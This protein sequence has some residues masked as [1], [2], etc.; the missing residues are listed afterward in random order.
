MRADGV[1]GPQLEDPL[2]ARLASGKETSWLRP[3]LDPAAQSLGACSLPEGLVE[4]ARRRFRRFAP[5][6]A[7][8]FPQTRAADGIIESPLERAGA[9]QSRMGELLGAELPG[10]LWVK[11]DDT[12]PV[13]G[14]I[15][16]RGGFH[17]VLQVVEGIVESEQLGA[18]GSDGHRLEGA[19][20]VGALRDPATARTLH[21][22]GIA[23]GSTGNLGLSIGLLAAEFGLRATVHM[24]TDA[25]PWKKDMLRSRGVEVVEHA[26]DFSAAVA[27]G[28]TAAGADPLTHFVDDES[29]LS[30][31]AGY[32]VAARRL[33]GQLAALEVTIDE[34]SPLFVYLPCGVG[35]GPGGVTYGL[36]QVFGDHVHCI[37]ME[38]TSAPSMVLGVRTGLHSEVSV[39]DIGLSG[40]TIADGLAVGR[41]S[42]LVGEQIGGMIDGF[43]TVADERMAALVSVLD[44]T[45]GWR[46]EPSATAGAIG[47]WRVM[48]DA[49]YREAR[50]LDA[51]SMA[52]AHH[53][54][55]STGGS[56]VPEDEMNGYLQ[57]GRAAQGIFCA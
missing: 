14:S 44:E 40:S 18:A 27:A 8:R 52:R 57:Q 56:M 11:R 4:D 48:A 5:W 21:Q 24:S 10:A 43:V 45:H 6:F 36:K 29:S 26:G 55:W 33:A 12:L 25:R 51:R 37:F 3:Q 7:D 13:S 20:G 47:P 50:G 9:L 35:G 30:L 2:V 38:P 49:A 23:V 42:R 39:Q 19:A 34:S 17:E 46:V 15:K 1:A 54:V 41:P 32:A 28:R 22:H 16:A 53:I 31:F